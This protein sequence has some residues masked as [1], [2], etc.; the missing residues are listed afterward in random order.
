M[1]VVRLYLKLLFGMGLPFGLLAG[2]E[3][4]EVQVGLV[5]GLFFGVFMS[6]V[7]GSITLYR[8]RGLGSDFSPRVTSVVRV[9]ADSAVVHRRVL[10]ILPVLPARVVADDGV[11]VVA[12]TR[13]NMQSWGERITVDVHPS[14]DDTEVTIRSVPRLRCTLV[15]YGR[16]RRNVDA[17]VR[18]LG[19]DLTGHL[20]AA[21]PA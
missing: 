16:G 20:G 9:P 3:S 15:D 19:T 12:R 10:E 2:L 18:A 13:A 5:A 1:H 17:L 14:A 11:H 7:F 6:I 21:S 4:G 8:Y